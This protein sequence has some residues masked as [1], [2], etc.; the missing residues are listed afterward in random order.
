MMK[1]W[2]FEEAV[3]RID[4][5]R[6]VIRAVANSEVGDYDRQIAAQGNRN[7]TWFLNTRIRSRVGD[8]EGRCNRGRWKTASW[9]KKHS[10]D[11]RIIPW[12][13]APLNELI[14]SEAG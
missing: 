10:N 8:Y 9:W 1:G 14:G 12:L 2:E 3:W 5:I 11:S 6:I 7:I 4:G 13:V